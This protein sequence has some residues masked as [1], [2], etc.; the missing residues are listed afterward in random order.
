MALALHAIL[1]A[2]HFQTLLGATF[3]AMFPDRVGRVIL[4]GVVD[5]DN[6]V[7]PVWEGSIQDSDAISSRF[8]KYC[9]E[10]ESLCAFY[11]PGESISDLEVRYNAILTDL[12]ENPISTIEPLTM[13]PVVLNYGDWRMLFF[14]T[15]YSPMTWPSIALFLDVYEKGYREVLA[16]TLSVAF[17]LAIDT[18]PFCA[19]PL[20]AYA[21][22]SEAQSAIMCSD[23]RYAV[24]HFS[25]H[26]CTY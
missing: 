19:A 6:Y 11:R 25:L 3:A 10:A 7:G 4:D 22:P 15:L 23:K 13:S 2:N 8:T 20:P 18:G 12:K 21:Y 5:A 17:G 14:Q 9:H 16:Q 1:V 26:R 24:C